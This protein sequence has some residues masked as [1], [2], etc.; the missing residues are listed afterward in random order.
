MDVFNLRERGGRSHE[1]PRG[2]TVRVIVLEMQRT[3]DADASRAT[4]WTM[5]ISSPYVGLPSGLCP[6][7][8]L[9]VKAGRLLSN[10][11]FSDTAANIDADGALGSG[12][13]VA[14]MRAH[15]AHAAL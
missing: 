10:S 3:C 9:G 14:T 6:G 15:P 12:A 8:R 5:G 13:I 4:C 1:S 2:R 7:T 11:W